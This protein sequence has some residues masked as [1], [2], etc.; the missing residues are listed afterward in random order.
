M[1]FSL[2]VITCINVLQMIARKSC[3]LTCSCDDSDKVL[4]SLALA[5]LPLSQSGTVAVIVN[6]DW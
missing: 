3:L 2:N 6:P 4:H 1:T 5:K